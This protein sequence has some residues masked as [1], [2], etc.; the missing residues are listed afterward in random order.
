MRNLE[1][2]KP[3]KSHNILCLIK[4]PENQQ[5]RVNFVATQIQDIVVLLKNCCKCLKIKHLATDNRQY[6]VTKV[7]YLVSDEIL[8]RLRGL[9][10][11]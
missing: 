6:I 5:K 2:T 4:T 10:I 3:A 9:K 8:A 7:S 1:K 11:N